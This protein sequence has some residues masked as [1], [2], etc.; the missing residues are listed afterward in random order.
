[1]RF[2]KTYLYFQKFFEKPLG[3]SKV[4]YDKENILFSFKSWNAC[5]RRVLC[6]MATCHT[7]SGIDYSVVVGVVVIVFLVLN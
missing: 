3:I 5:L 2:P 1:M 4:Q 7:T 6:R